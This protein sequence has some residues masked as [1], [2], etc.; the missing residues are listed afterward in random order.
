M[1]KYV[2]TVSLGII[3]ICILLLILLGLRPRDLF[4]PS[5][6]FLGGRSPVVYR[7]PRCDKILYKQQLYIYSFEAGFNHVCSNADA[8]LFP[9]GFVNSQPDEIR[10]PGSNERQR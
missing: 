2:I 5:Y 4:V 3:T 1:K 9:E 6:S 10:S 7:E 8:E